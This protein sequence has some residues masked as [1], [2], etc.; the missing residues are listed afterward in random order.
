M[1]LKGMHPSRPLFPLG[2]FPSV[3]LQSCFSSALV[4]CFS[5]LL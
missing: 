2:S 1:P 3:L 4:P 5:S